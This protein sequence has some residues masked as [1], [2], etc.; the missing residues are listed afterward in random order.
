MNKR[1]DTSLLFQGHGDLLPLIPTSTI[2]RKQST[3][4]SFRLDCPKLFSPVLLDTLKTHTKPELFKVPCRP[5]EDTEDSTP[6]EIWEDIPTEASTLP[7]SQ[8]FT[9]AAHETDLSFAFALT[10]K[11]YQH[12]LTEELRH[13]LRLWKH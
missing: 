9:E 4:N 1:Y 7:N 13:N 3:K 8:D 2:A 11:P 6:C 12:T 10:K 5:I